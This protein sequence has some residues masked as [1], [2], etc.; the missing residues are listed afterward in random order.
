[1]YKIILCHRRKKGCGYAEFHAHWREQRGRLVLG[2][3][4]ELGYSSY[5]QMHQ[6]HRTNLLYQAIRASRGRLVIGLLSLKQGRKVPQLNPDQDTRREEQWDVMDE[7]WYPTRESLVQAVTAKTGI[8]AARRLAE[9][10][11]P[12]VRR[13]AVIIGE[14][15]V[16]AADR[17]LSS[18]RT[19]VAFCLRSRPDMTREEMLTYWGG[20]HKKL[21][22]SL[23]N[24]LK[25]HAYQ[26]LHVHGAPEFSDIVANLGGSTGEEFN[27]VAGLTFGSQWELAL[28]F[29]NPWSQLANLKVIQDE[30]NFIDHQRSVLVFGR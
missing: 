23:Q 15:F 13:T 4:A 17:G 21:F 24:S 16:M 3:Q 14:E 22:L 25:Y 8:D 10:H 1:M 2:L 7:F 19:R 20:H 18:M 27:G 28:A 5:A 6:A 26:Q 30:T 29:L 9:D 11:A 12:W